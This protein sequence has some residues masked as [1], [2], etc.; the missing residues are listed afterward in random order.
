MSMYYSRIVALFVIFCAFVV[1]VAC[2]S[3]DGESAGPQVLLTLQIDAEHNLEGDNWIFASD[4]NGAVLDVK[5]YSAGQTV[6]LSGVDETDKVTITF[7]QSGTNTD[8]DYP[9]IETYTDIAKG[10]TLHLEAN[11]TTPPD[12]VTFKISG[13]SNLA[14][15][16][17]TGFSSGYS[18]GLDGVQSGDLLNEVVSLYDAT[19]PC[20]I[21]VSGY[22]SDVPVYNWAKGVHVGDVISR[23]FATDFTPFPHQ[24]TLDL[25]GKYGVSVSGIDLKRSLAIELIQTYW[26]SSQVVNKPV[27]GY[28]DGFDAYAVRARG[29]KENGKV[30]YSQIGDVP[31]FSFTLPDFTLSV[32]NE[33]MAGFAFNFSQDYTYYRASWGVSTATSNRLWDVIAPAGRSPKNLILPDEIK[34]KYPEFDQT[35]LAYL[36]LN[37]VHVV[38]G[39]PYPETMPGMPGVKFGESEHYNYYSN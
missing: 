7:F 29:I 24:T 12:K 11:P 2:D 14:G 18:S 1:V 25:V 6:T 23:N 19:F 26:L 37:L 35:K 39:Q 33:N 22:R 3:S 36:Y 30:I 27:V 32:T 5:P 16:L 31:N 15:D 10:T 9:F 28:I 20:D 4:E 13:V 21:L 38:K 34:T 8:G 17:L